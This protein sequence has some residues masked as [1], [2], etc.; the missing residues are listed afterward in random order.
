MSVMSGSVFGSL[1]SRAKNCKYRNLILLVTVLSVLGAMALLV[2]DAGRAAA[3]QSQ[4]ER[5]SY[6]KGEKE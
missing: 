5:N 6:G 1:V 3:D 4:I 2:S